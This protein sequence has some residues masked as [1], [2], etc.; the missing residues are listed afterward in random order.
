M[1]FRKEW[2]NKEEEILST[3]IETI[4]DGII[5]IDQYSKVVYVNPAFRAKYNLPNKNDKIE[6][7]L[8][9][10]RF[11]H[12][13]GKTLITE[14]ENPINKVLNK[15]DVEDMEIGFKLP[16]YP[17]HFYNIKGK[18]LYD[19][20]TNQ[21]VGAVF[22]AHEITKRKATEDDLNKSREDFLNLFEHSPEAMV[23]HRER[24][25][26]Y[27]N[28]AAVRL[29][30]A[31]NVED[32]IGKSLMHMFPKDI[33]EETEA[34][35]MQALKGDVETKEY[36][37]R[38]LDGSDIYVELNLKKINFQ[39]KPALLS[40]GR[41]TSEKNKMMEKIQESEERY[42]SLFMNHSDAIMTFDEKGNFVSCNPMVDDISG[43][44][45]EELVGKPFAPLII[46]KDTEKVKEHFLKALQGETQ[47][48][49]CQIKHKDGHIV[50]LQLTTVPIIIKGR[51]VGVFGVAKDIT[52]QKEMEEKI[53][54]LAFHD[55][56]TG[57]PNR[58]L[59]TEKLAKSIDNAKKENGKLAVVFLDLDRFKFINDTLGHLAGDELLMKVANRLE[60]VLSFEDTV[61]RLGGD[62]FIIL[63]NNINEIDIDKIGK[64][65][66]ENFQEPFFIN[67]QEIHTTPSIGISMYP[68]S[69]A[70]ID[71]LIKNADI[72][73][74]GAKEQGKNNYQ[75]YS[76]KM[77]KLIQR[78][79]Q[80]EKGLRNAISK[81][82]LYLVYQPQYQLRT[83]NMTGAEA[84][85]R[86]KHPEWGPISPAEFIPIAEETGLIVSIGEWVI[87][88]ALIQLRSWLDQGHFP[89]R[90]SINISV[91]QIREQNIYRFIKKLLQ[92]Y[93]IPAKLIC[94]EITETVLQKRD[95]AVPVLQKLHSLGICIS[96]D[97]FGTGFSSLSYLKHF[98]LDV[99]KVDK[100]F[101]DDISN[102]QKDYPIIQS[103][104]D[105]GKNLNLQVIAEGIETE[106]QLLLLEKMD[107]DI[108][109]GYYLNKPLS[110]DDFK[111]IM[112]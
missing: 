24:V 21:V 78:K 27:A 51:V 47:H 3:A 104:I 88:E 67:E 46:P 83:K 43:Y 76:N 103:I 65:I 50:Q 69:G 15:Y 23:I 41:D 4:E 62:E 34:R 31:S 9:L 38:A 105:L 86:W 66:L 112:P 73:M 44:K 48:Y 42:R 64:K 93:N 91:R 6:D 19:K 33:R 20:K 111:I 29:L 72:A 79:T 32:L 52:E 63:L 36:K 17:M 57:L 54:H 14:E 5:V 102:G 35:M 77:N 75:F 53:K 11:Y 39:G 8:N 61:S 81:E 40:I 107:C 56:L 100:S 13:D 84:L 58:K 95:E 26:I 68:D 74:Y 87:E 89:M 59:F 28:D 85:L 55:D 18:S 70:D 37:L 80:I 106:D 22:T 10:C 98:P 2:E 101:V 71:T 7:W 99:L 60:G 110:S 30:K 96:I 49:E 109:Q 12:A 82:E 108:G 92:K 45:P 25:I 94:L 90:M 1:F 97:D 16:Q